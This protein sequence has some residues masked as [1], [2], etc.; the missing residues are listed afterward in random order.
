MNEFLS[1]P[2]A[3][4]SL[5]LCASVCLAGLSACASSTARNPPPGMDAAVAPPVDMTGPITQP[6]PDLATGLNPGTLPFTVDQVYI[7]SGFMGD[8]ATPGA[9][10][11][12]PTM[13][14]DSK[15]CNGQRSSASAKGICHQAT[16]APPTTTPMLWAG[17]YWQYPSNNWGMRSGFAIPTG[18]TKVVFYAKGAKGGEKVKFL[19]GGVADPANPHQDTVMASSEATLTTDWAQYSISIAGQT[20]NEVLGGFGWTMAAPN[21]TTGGSF[22]VDDIQWQ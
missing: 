8:G 20:Y 3:R 12:L 17:V 4:R 10:V 2:N 6:P 11:M 5:F 16:Y 14:G 22:F 15:D 9:V 19:A 1:S 13:P 21:A 7:P 18:A